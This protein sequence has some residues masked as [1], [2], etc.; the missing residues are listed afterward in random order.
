MSTLP[1][2]T[3]GYV[4]AFNL[5]EINEDRGEWAPNCA[6]IRSD[7]GVVL[8][9]P[10]YGVTMKQRRSWARMAASR[11]EN[12]IELPGFGTIRI[13]GQFKVLS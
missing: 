11:A 1:S 7:T 13:Y 8:T 3:H 12:R 5:R 10:G 6:L 4:R 2:T 9:Q